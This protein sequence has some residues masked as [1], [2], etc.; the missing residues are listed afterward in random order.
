M[1]IKTAALLLAILLV[2]GIILIGYVLKIQIPLLRV[3]DARIY[4]IMRYVLFFVSV[5]NL[6][7]M[8]LL[9]SVDLATVFFGLQRSARVIN[10]V[11][12]VVTF[13][14]AIIMLSYAFGFAVMYWSIGK[15]NAAASKLI[16][17]EENPRG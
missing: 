17:R 5:I 14:G 1:D 7:G 3:K 4:V 11:G 8:L 2:V 13:T 12:V 10:P 15:D 9:L 16:K 6:V